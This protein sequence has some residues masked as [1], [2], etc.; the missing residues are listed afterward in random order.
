MGSI[1]VANRPGAGEPSP[2]DD[3]SHACVG[4]AVAAAAAASLASGG[5][6]MAAAAQWRRLEAAAA[7]AAAEE[8]AEVVRGGL[9]EHTRCER[10]SVCAHGWARGQGGRGLRGE[11]AP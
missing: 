10:A 9:R 4:D 2:S 6:A 1:P 8:T 5:G 7:V 3:G 11:C